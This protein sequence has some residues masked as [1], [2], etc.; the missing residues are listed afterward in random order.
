MQKSKLTDQGQELVKQGVELN[1]QLLAFLGAVSVE[2]VED[3]SILRRT[4]VDCVS[5]Y[6]LRD[7]DD[8]R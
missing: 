3:A 1:S 6:F 5:V 4:A 7:R 8:I 2:E